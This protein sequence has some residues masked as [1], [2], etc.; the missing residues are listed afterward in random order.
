MDDLNIASI[1][2]TSYDHNIDNSANN[3]YCDHAYNTSSNPDSEFV[4]ALNQRAEIYKMVWSIGGATKN[5]T[6]FQFFSDL[7]MGQLEELEGNICDILGP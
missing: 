3:S 6:P 2:A 7:I 5:S 4:S 1:T